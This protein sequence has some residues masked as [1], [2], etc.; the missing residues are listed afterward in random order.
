MLKVRLAAAYL[1]IAMILPASSTLL[2]QTAEAPA[3]PVP[4]QIGT[5]KKVFISNA[6]VDKDETYNGFY[7]AIKS[8]G[9]YELMAAP[10]DADLVLEISF[11]TRITS[12]YGSKESGCDSSNTSQLKLVLVDTKTRIPL[13]TVTET[14]KP[15]GRQKTAEKN[16]SDAINKLVGDLKTLSTQPAAK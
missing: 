15:A 5:A 16:L 6:G 11:S 7:A 12:V 3:T 8:W 9:Q 2:A 1:G 10:A 14:I 4:A 13:W